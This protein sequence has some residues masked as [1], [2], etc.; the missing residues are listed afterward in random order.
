MLQDVSVGIRMV[1]DYLMFPLGLVSSQYREDYVEGFNAFSDVRERDLERMK[2]QE[3]EL[4]NSS[5]DHSHAE[6]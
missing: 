2:G 1:H 5:W 4:V 6:P 3:V